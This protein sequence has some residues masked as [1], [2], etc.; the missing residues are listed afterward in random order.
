MSDHLTSLPVEFLFTMHATLDRA[1]TVAAAPYGRR[2]IVNVTGG[3]VVGPRINGT[4]LASGGD[5]VTGRGDGVSLLDVRVVIATDDDMTICM[6][7]QGLLGTDR[8]ARVAPLFQTSDGPYAWLNHVQAI[9]IGRSGP[10][11]VTYD[12]YALQ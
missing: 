11:D 9:G 2:V 8:I 5:W 1:A 4:L 12:I 10:G 7:Y 3:T 6:T